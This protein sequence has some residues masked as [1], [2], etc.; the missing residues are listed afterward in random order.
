MAEQ[1]SSSRTDGALGCGFILA[2]VFAI[3][4]VVIHANIFNFIVIGAIIG[5]LVGL[6]ADPEAAD[7]GHK[8]KS[9]RS[10]KRKA[11][12][13]VVVGRNSSPLAKS[14][15]RR[16]DVSRLEVPGGYVPFEMTRTETKTK[17]YVKTE[18][19]IKTYIDAEEVRAVL[20]GSD[21]DVLSDGRM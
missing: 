9:K 20:K 4:A 16:R 8:E 13:G 6:F 21:V 19:K 5:A 18:T 12:E 10:G 11:R 14:I 15:E 2:I 1:T 17:D 3:I 7:S